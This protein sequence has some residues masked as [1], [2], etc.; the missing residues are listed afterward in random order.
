[1]LR[2]S[3]PSQPVR[4]DIGPCPMLLV[5]PIR[6]RRERWNPSMSLSGHREGEG[7]EARDTRGPVHEAREG[8]VAS[9]RDHVQEKR[10]RA[11]G[12]GRVAALLSKPLD[13]PFRPTRGREEEER[14]SKRVGL[15]QGGVFDS[16]P[17]S[18]RGEHPV[19]PSG[20]LSGRREGRGRRGRGGERVM[21]RRAWRTPVSP[22]KRRP[23]RSARGPASAEGGKTAE[24]EHPRGARR[25]DDAGDVHAQAVARDVEHVDREG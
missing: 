6:L 22:R 21:V 19:N 17:A 11:A 23:R 8:G 5:L 15:S 18:E 24:R 10:P 13:G 12:T 1:M 20:V 2:R 16:R 14:S 3:A 4:S 7:R 25:W 9:A